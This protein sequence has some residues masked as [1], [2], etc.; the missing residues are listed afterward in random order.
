METE[1]KSSDLLSRLS[2]PKEKL[3]EVH[4]AAKHLHKS[5]S[6]LYRL[7]KDEQLRV[8]RTGPRGILVVESSLNEYVTSINKVK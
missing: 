7:I 1:N 4:I 3:L 6:S 5:V 2:D 8:I